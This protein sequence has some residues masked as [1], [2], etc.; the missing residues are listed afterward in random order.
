MSEQREYACRIPQ[1]L[2]DDPPMW[3]AFW[4]RLVQMEGYAPVGEPELERHD[5]VSMNGEQVFPDDEPMFI[6]RGHVVPSTSE[7]ET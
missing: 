5:P 1:R 3:R 4:G 6:V 2:A 7:G